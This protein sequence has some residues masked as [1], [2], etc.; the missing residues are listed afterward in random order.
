MTEAL[1]EI[2][3]RA[4]VVPVIVVDDIRHAAPL[5]EA[6]VSGGLTVLEVTLRTPVA[7]DV[8]TAMRRAVPEAVVGVG[9]I[10]ETS[11]VQASVD[12]GAQF[13]VSPGLHPDLVDATRAA[14]LPYL[15]GIATVSELMQARL[16][17][18]RVCKFFPAQQAGG[19]A[20]LRTFHSVIPDVHFCPTGGID[21]RNAPEFLALP[22]VLCVGGSW[23][24]PAALLK[25]GGWDQITALAQA[26]ATMGRT[27]Q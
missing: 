23:V 21:A 3:K 17:G 27:S 14:N 26:A 2:L 12:A 4:V 16:L 20:M 6:L 22:N 7:L 9:T 19:V 11:H 15:P 5:A 8:I 1:H 24:T 18:L 13:G 10:T 25:S